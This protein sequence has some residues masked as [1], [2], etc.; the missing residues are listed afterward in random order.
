LPD[1]ENLLLYAGN[2]YMLI[3][4]VA[5]ITPCIVRAVPA[6]DTAHNS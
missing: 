6:V 4:I 1:H 2:Y 3:L 5:C